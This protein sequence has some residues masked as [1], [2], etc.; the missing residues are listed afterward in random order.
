MIQR[1][2]IVFINSPTFILLDFLDFLFALIK[3][4]LEFLSIF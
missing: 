4:H 1:E 2:I 3:L